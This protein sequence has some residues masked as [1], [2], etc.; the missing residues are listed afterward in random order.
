M[1]V[2]RVASTA[3]LSIVAAFTA[4]VE[5]ATKNV[6]TAPVVPT[7]CGRNWM[8]AVAFDT[9][10]PMLEVTVIGKIGVCALTISLVSPEYT[11]ALRLAGSAATE[12]TSTAAT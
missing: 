6:K 12:W 11:A 1:P 5:G 7:S 4:L 3:L 10:G 9:V 2:G 8:L